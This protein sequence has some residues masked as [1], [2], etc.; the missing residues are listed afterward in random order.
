MSTGEPRRASTARVQR[1]RSREGGVCGVCLVAV[2]GVGNVKQA[3]R[4]VSHRKVVIC[5]HKVAHVLHET[6]ERCI[7]GQRAFFERPAKRRPRA[8]CTIRLLW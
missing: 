3:K 2:E 4:C 7:L 1:A 5:G 6:L 8:P